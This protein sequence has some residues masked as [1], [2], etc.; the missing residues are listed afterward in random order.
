MSRIRFGVVGAGWRAEFF[1][2]IA[3]AAPEHFELPLV[4]ARDPQK[5]KRFAAQWQCPVSASVA[6]M[7]AGDALDFVVTSVSWGANPGIVKELVRRGIP[8]LSETP[9]AADLAAMIDLWQHVEEHQ[10]RVCVAEQYF[11]QPYFAA[12]RQVIAL[13]KIGTVSQA[14]VSAA[15]GYHGMSLMRKLLGIGYGNATIASRAFTAPLVEGPGRDNPPTAE[16]VA[17]CTQAFFWLDFDGKLGL[18]DFCGEQ[19]FNWVRNNRVLVRGERG[20]ITNDKVVYL[21]DFR[22][23]IYLGLLR[24]STGGP[25]NLEGNYLKGIQLGE[26]MVY[27]NPLA[28]AALSDDEIAIGDMMLR[29]AQY[30]RGSE[31]A[32]YPLAEACQ[33]HYLGLMCEQALK[34]GA[35]VKTRTQPWSAGL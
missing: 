10:G 4:V 20:E 12:L 8:V 7:L 16:V 33:D 34:S 2:R 3:A 28:P 23:P 26:N 14:Q 5:A 32:P 30:V 17:D 29:M 1:L 27:A 6:E 18:M 11:L 21:Q 25:G 31:T 13:G 9:P 19:Y 15:H 22:T 24:H 35:E